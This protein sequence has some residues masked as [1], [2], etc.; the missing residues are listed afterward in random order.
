MARKSKPKPKTPYEPAWFAIRTATRQE[1]RA[2]GALRDLGL[3]V[4]LPV[5]HYAARHARTETR[6]AR[7]LFVGYVFAKLREADIYF[8]EIADGVHCIIGADRTYNTIEEDVLGQLAFAEWLG[9]FDR[10]WK[11]GPPRMKVKPR[12]KIQVVSGKLSGAFG[13]VLEAR[14]DHRAAVLLE[15]F[16]MRRKVTLSLSDLK[17]A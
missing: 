16:G 7:P 17:A 9:V 2:A 13:E 15:L 11:S 5:E 14:G 12:D 10:T 3:E 4:Y 1:F 8:A 6:K